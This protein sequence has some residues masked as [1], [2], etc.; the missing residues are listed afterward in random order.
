MASSKSAVKI[1]IHP[2]KATRLKIT[3]TPLQLIYVNMPL[4]HSFSFAQFTWCPVPPLNSNL[5]GVGPA[6][7]IGL[8][9][10]E[11]NK[12]LKKNPQNPRDSCWPV[13]AVLC[14]C[15]IL[16]EEPLQRSDLFFPFLAL[17]H[18]SFP[19]TGLFRCYFQN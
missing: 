7:G 5:T 8:G 12:D 18:F 16:Q 3:L 11:G 13:S 9:S 1:L 17:L 4:R 14:F 19:T 6:L 15:V 10:G 2:P